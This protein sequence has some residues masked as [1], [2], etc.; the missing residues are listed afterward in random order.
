MKPRPLFV[1]LVVGLV[2]ALVLVLYLRRLE[3]EA[4]GG[5]KVAVLVAVET[6]GRGKTITES[7]LGTRDI[8]AAYLDERVVRAA[9]KDKVVGLRATMTVPVQQGLAWSDVMAPKDD[10]RALSALVQP[11]SRATPIR[12]EITDVLALVRPGDFVDIVCV[13][14]ESKDAAV[15]LQRV[16]VLAAGTSTAAPKGD[17]RESAAQRRVT[18]LTVSVS[19]QESQLL[20]VAMEKGKLAVA[21]R[22]PTDPRI[23]EAPTDVSAQT[24]TDSSRRQALQG[25]RR[26]ARGGPI[27]LKETK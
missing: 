14:G 12:V 24:L 8:P 5:K 22:N 17:G 4:A 19:L 21:V 6:I 9:D 7:M 16:L 10:E 25:A 13:C 2:G 26:P 15:L 27:E 20:A 3:L 1:G 11:G 18:V 23:T